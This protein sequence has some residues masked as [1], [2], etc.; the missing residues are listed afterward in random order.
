MQV[1]NPGQLDF[2]GE[3]WELRKLQIFG[4]QYVATA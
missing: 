4:F 2:A 3:P 1:Y